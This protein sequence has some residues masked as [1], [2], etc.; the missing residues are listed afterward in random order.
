[1]NYVPTSTPQPIGGVIDDAIRLFRASWSR[2]WLLVVVP[3][4]A[5]ILSLLVVPLNVPTNIKPSS[6]ASF[7]Q[8]YETVYTPRVIGFYLLLSVVS[9]IFQGAVF[10]YEAA[11]VGGN[12]TVSL[13]D[14]I[15]TGVRK[16]LWMI[17]GWIL[18]SIVVGIGLV[19]LLIPGIWLWGRLMFWIPALFVDG[20]NSVDALGTSWRLTRG[21]WWRG[22][23]TVSVALIIALVLALVF[24][25]VGGIVAGFVLAASHMD[26]RSR[27]LVMQIFSTMGNVIYIPLIAAMWIATYRDFKLRR[28]GGDLASRAAALGSA[29]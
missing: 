4:L 18:F 19:A 5:S 21:N 11:I 12:Q 7:L 1:M 16:V 8:M 25:S 13:T 28:E 22:T 17:L 2:C 29:A 14:A 27:V 20:Q 10:A 26:P 6:L 23:V 15:G 3:G 9:L 24:T